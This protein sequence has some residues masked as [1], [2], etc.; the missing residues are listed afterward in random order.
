MDKDIETLGETVL[1]H[2]SVDQRVI[3]MMFRVLLI[4]ASS[5]KILACLDVL[6]VLRDQFEGMFV[7]AD[8]ATK[9]QHE[10]GLRHFERWY[11]EL[12]GQMQEALKSAR[13]RE[14]H[15]GR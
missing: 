1:I 9:E 11:T 3:S 15:G 4:D 6:D 13:K 5:A 12:E 2:R 14:A 8:E 7:N 10:S